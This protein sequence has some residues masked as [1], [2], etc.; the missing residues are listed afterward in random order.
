MDSLSPNHTPEGAPAKKR[1]QG[2]VSVSG[3]TVQWHE[4]GSGE[5]LFTRPGAAAVSVGELHLSKEEELSLANQLMA[6][7][8]SYGFPDGN[9]FFTVAAAITDDGKMVLDT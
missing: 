5:I 8:R 7:Y 3:Q 6:H 1:T 2:S 4:D 9:G